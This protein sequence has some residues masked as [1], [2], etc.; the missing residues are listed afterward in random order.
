MRKAGLPEVLTVNGRAE[1]VLQ[2]AEVYQAMMNR[3]ELYENPIQVAAAMSDRSRN[4]SW[5]D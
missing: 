4:P 2:T 1:R 3:L 5:V